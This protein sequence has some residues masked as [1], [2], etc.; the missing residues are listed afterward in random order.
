M[1]ELERL[2]K[3]EDL[4]KLLCDKLF[5]INKHPSYLSVFSFC[6]NHGFPYNGPN[7][8]DEL[9]DLRNVLAGKE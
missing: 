9:I 5:L 7:Y 6:A 8:S 4:S 3:I 1:T 2:K